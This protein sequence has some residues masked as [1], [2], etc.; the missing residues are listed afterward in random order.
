[1]QTQCI[2]AAGLPARLV[3]RMQTV[4]DSLKHSRPCAA[5]DVARTPLALAISAAQAALA[6]LGHVQTPLE[7]Q[8]MDESKR[9]QRQLHELEKLV[10]AA[11]V[12]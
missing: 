7:G 5:L 11:L 12:S 3:A 9:I 8:Q 4:H 6:G 2:A 1:M 10:E